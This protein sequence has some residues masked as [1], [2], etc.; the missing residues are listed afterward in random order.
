MFQVKKSPG[1]LMRKWAYAIKMA[2]TE[3]RPKGEG[4]VEVNNWAYIQGVPFITKA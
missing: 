2:L 3:I 1:I 4:W